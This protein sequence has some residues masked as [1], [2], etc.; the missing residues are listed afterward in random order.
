V[1]LRV[2]LLVAVSVAALLALVVADV[3]IYR[4]LRSYLYDRVDTELTS[5]RRT[6]EAGIQIPADLSAAA[7]LIPGTFVQLRTPDGT[8][9]FT[10]GWRRFGED[11][12]P[13]I[14]PAIPGLD[15]R[16]NPGPVFFSTH[17]E[18]PGG[19]SF[20][21]RAEL[22]ADGVQ[23]IFA[24][25][26]DNTNQTLHRLLA[27][28]VLVTAGALIASVALG[29]SLV[30]IG[31]RPLARMEETADAIVGGDALDRRIPG[32]T[33][34][35]EVGRLARSLNTMLGR[36]QVAFSQRDATEAELRRSEQRLRRFVSDAS[37]ELRTPLAAIS[38]YAELYDRAGTEHE[39]DRPRM[40]A[41]IRS[42]T[43]R[44]GRLV[45]DLLLLARLDEGQP[46]EH[47]TVELVSVAAEAV[48]AAAAVGPDWP[49]RL[50]A[51][52][53]V[54]V[55]GDPARIRQVLDN[56]L[57]NARA[58]T[59]ALTSVTV[60]VARTGDRGVLEV[61]DDGPGLAPED[62]S[63]VFERFYRTDE[64]R[65]RRS[66]GTGLGLAIVAAIVEAHGGNVTLHTVPG[67]GAR[68]TVELPLAGGAPAP[69]T[70]DAAEWAPVGSSDG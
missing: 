18:Q 40:L 53:P 47:R 28:E 59:P 62:A 67:H 19:P 55:T 8:A 46:L 6:V 54:E 25:P 34:R 21:V 66:G 3:A 61:A 10:Q 38:A 26:L 24:T 42:E 56:L 36:L 4:A 35:S 31:L 41:G 57:A 32:E 11:Q 7:D 63:R 37:H 51:G 12:T 52:G 17:A 13:A 16:G 60:R 43:A 45:E 70:P 22:L 15:A 68:F 39:A 14:P 58:H 48:D 29:A 5:A 1:S 65:S 50:E 9:V 20:R 44:M 33:E 30:G 23:L 64:S 2:R 27:V 69:T 49:I